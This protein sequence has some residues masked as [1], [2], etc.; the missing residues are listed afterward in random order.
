VVV[1]T[2]LA[3]V[4]LKTKW[5]G[6]RIVEVVATLPIGVPPVVFSAALLITLFSVPGFV[7]LYGT[8]VPLVV[9][10]VV[11]TLPFAIRVISGALISIQNSLLEASAA[12][13]ASGARTMRKIVLPLLLPA[14][15]NAAMLV[16]IRSFLQLGAVVFLITPSFNLLPTQI[17]ST[18]GVGQYGIVSALNVLSVLLPMAVF[19]LALGVRAA[20]QAGSRRRLS[21]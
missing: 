4:A 11:V 19:A 14:A 20:V 9:A 10:D 16:Y 6:R 5:R 12:S 7:S 3:F 17:F 21:T 13:G 1:A 18:W 8:I 2:A 15:T